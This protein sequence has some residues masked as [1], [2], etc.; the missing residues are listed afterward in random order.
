MKERPRKHGHVVMLSKQNVGRIPKIY[1][2]QNLA[3]PNLI[4]NMCV[5]VRV[6]NVWREGFTD[7]AEK[8]VTKFFHAG[9]HVHSHAV[10]YARL[11]V[12]HVIGFVRMD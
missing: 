11:V 4:A 9:I 2:A 8:P 1:H 10:K 7:P 3:L 6:E 12:E 5:Q